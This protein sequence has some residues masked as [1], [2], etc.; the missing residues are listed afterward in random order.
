MKS[1]FYYGFREGAKWVNHIASEQKEYDEDSF[2]AI[3][4]ENVLKAI[5]KQKAIDIEKACEWLKENRKS[6]FIDDSGCD[7]GRSA[8]LS[9][10][11]IDAF[12]EA[13]EE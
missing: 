1:S 5:E 4:E 7:F 6:D 11:F 3:I 9:E 8:E 13:M 2:H 10:Y 12:R